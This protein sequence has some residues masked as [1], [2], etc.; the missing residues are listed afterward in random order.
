MTDQVLVPLRQQSL[1]VTSNSEGDERV[2]VLVTRAQ[3]GDGDSFGQIYSLLVPKVYAYVLARL[4]SRQDAEDVTTLAWVRAWT[5]LGR[6]RP[7]GSFASWLFTIVRRAVAD[8]YRRHRPETVPIDNQV[9]TLLDTAA[10]AE[11]RTLSVERV[12]RVSAI[13]ATLTA[14][15]QDVLALRFLAELP[16]RDIARIMGKREP[17]VKMLA[18]RG[19]AETRRRYEHENPTAG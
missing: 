15:Q 10:G 1:A 18:Y 13:I 19:L 8:H 12:Q 9:E 16:Y 6:Y 3:A 7:T 2:A 17:A 4:R 11:E 14:D 5:S